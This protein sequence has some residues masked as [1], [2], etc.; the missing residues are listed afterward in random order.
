MKGQ[1]ITGI[2]EINPERDTNVCAKF[3]GNPFN[4]S[5]DISLKITNMQF[6]V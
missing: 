3:H 2:P 4:N 6:L 5:L 1:V